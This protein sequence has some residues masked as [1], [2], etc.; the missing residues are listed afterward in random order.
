[1]VFAHITFSQTTKGQDLILVIFLVFLL[2]KLGVKF[3]CII[4]S[5]ASGKTHFQFPLCFNGPYKK[6]KMKTEKVVL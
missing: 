3:G 4:I 5:F 2:E 1:M 6:L